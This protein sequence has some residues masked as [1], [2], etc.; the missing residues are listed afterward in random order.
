MLLTAVATG[1]IGII[2]AHLLLGVGFV[3]SFGIRPLTTPRTYHRSLGKIG[4]A[5]TGKL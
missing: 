4:I 2:A 3:G 1:S 5:S